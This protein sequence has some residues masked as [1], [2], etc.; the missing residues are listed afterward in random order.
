MVFLQI[1]EALFYEQSIE[2]VQFGTG[3]ETLGFLSSG[4]CDLICTALH[5]PDMSC[6]AFSQEVRRIPSA[7]LIPLVMITS[8]EKK[9]YF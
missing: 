6:I 9:R 8:E 3:R 2:M 1:P 5:L 7:V 4:S